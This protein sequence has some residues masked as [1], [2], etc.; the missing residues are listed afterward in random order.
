MQPMVAPRQV[1]TEIMRGKYAPTR[2]PDVSSRI[3]VVTEEVNVRQVVH[4]V[5]WGIDGPPTQLN[6]DRRS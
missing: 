5:C 3:I 4:P 6:S 2:S 1:D